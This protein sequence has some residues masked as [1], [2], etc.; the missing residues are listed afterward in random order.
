MDGA[1]D[2]GPVLM[3]S[4]L[5]RCHSLLD[6]LNRFKAFIEVTKQK[7]P[8]IKSEYAVDTKHFHGVV[9][10]ELKSLQRV[11]LAFLIELSPYDDT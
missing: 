6:E 4:L 9:Q 7:G 10:G 11:G 3:D 8:K 1:D 2:E 5:Q